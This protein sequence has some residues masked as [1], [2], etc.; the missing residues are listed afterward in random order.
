MALSDR[1]QRQIA[2]LQTKRDTLD[3]N[4]Q[5]ERAKIVSKIQALKNLKQSWNAELDS[6]LDAAGQSGVDLNT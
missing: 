5:A 4:Y 1:L 3:A 2:D 6:L